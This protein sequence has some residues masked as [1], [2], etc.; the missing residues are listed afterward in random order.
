MFGKPAW[1]RKKPSSRGLS[2]VSW[3]GW[4]Y[5]AVW[6]AVIAIPF[7]ALLTHHLVIESLVWVAA[8]AGALVFDVRLVLRGLDHGSPTPPA[9]TGAQAA[10]KGATGPPAQATAAQAAS[11]GRGNAGAT[12]RD[13]EVMF[14]D[15]N[16][17]PDQA[18]FHTRSY[19]F[20]W[21]R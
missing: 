14:I 18:H 17:V 6:M 12:G 1:F 20:H 8:A 16:T 7:V 19:D 13:S 15:E 10:D 2:P 21:R 4:V 9:R 5:M 3:Q 11:A